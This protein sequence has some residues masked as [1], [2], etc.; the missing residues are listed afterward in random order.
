MNGLHCEDDGFKNQVKYVWS[1]Y[2]QYLQ[3]PCW[4]PPNQLLF[5][6]HWNRYKRQADR[7]ISDV[8]NR[9]KHFTDIL[10]ENTGRPEVMNTYC[11]TFPENGFSDRKV[12]SSML[13]TVPP[14]QRFLTQQVSMNHWMRWALGARKA[15]KK[16][17]SRNQSRPLSDAQGSYLLTNRVCHWARKWTVHALHEKALLCSELLQ[18]LPDCSPSYYL[19][20]QQIHRNIW[21]K[22]SY[23][24]HFTA[25]LLLTGFCFWAVIFTLQKDMLLIKHTLF[26]KCYKQYVTLPDPSG[27]EEGDQDGDLRQQSWWSCFC[28]SRMLAASSFHLYLA[29]QHSS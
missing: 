26:C 24:V 5:Q 11:D 19:R 16:I 3:Q 25:S 12:R 18:L 14:V 10:L 15:G 7:L 13:T 9:W 21:I 23:G 28:N 29:G 1:S 17:T 27:T 22:Y 8:C 4:I 2:V 20:Y 6:T